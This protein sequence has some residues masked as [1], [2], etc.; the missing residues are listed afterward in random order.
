MAVARRHRRC[1]HRADRGRHRSPD[2]TGAAIAAGAADA[3]HHRR[4]P[5]QAQLRG[6]TISPD[7]LTIVYATNRR[8]DSVISDVGLHAIAGTDDSM[9]PF[10]SA[11]G[12]W[13]GFFSGAEAKLKKVALTGGAPVTICDMAG[14]LRGTMWTRDNQILLASDGIKRVPANGGVLETLIAPK[15]G[16]VMQ[17]PQLLPDG[18]HIVFAI[19]ANVGL[20]WDAARLSSS[21]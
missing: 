1:G 3:F 13:V 18:D 14:A 20:N 16:E 4:P 15:P 10:F 5:E 8:A 19:G 21:R 12:K 11:D 6:I 9:G 7:G 2:A 17:G